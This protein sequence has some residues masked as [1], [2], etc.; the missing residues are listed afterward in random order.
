MSLNS[1]EHTQTLTDDNLLTIFRVAIFSRFLLAAISYLVVPSVIKAQTEISFL[2]T[3][4]TL[5]LSIY[6]F[7]PIFR[8]WL[9]KYFLPIALLWATVIPLLITTYS[10]YL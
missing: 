4:D 8:H 7:L 5:L 3:I 6:L 2:N 10:L 1:R 9:G